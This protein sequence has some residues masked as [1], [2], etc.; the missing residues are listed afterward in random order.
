MADWNA[1]GAAGVTNVGSNPTVDHQSV[2]KN[3]PT[4]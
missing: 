3:L 4:A 2:L 1:A